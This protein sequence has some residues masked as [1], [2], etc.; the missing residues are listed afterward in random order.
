MPVPES[1][2]ARSG[3]L[4]YAK[5]AD[6]LVAFYRHLLGM[7]LSHKDEGLTVLT[8]ADTQLLIHA[9]PPGIAERVE[10]TTPPTSRLQSAIK[11]FFTVDN[12]DLAVERLRGLGGL[13]LPGAWSNPVFQVINAVDP[14]GNVFHLRELV[15]AQPN[16]E[17]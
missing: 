11:L 14:E 13:A 16:H 2:P 9:L 12:L 4:I 7:E 8:N 3:A 5:D 15:Y 6:R 10:I 17:D 1:G